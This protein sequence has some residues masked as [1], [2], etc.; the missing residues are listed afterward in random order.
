MDNRQNF[1]DIVNKFIYGGEYIPPK[2][3][4]WFE[5]KHLAEIHSMLGI[6]GVV[7]NRSNIK[8]PLE[9]YEMFDFMVFDGARRG[10]LTES[11]FSDATSALNKA[12]IPHIVVKGYILRDLY[13]EKDMRSMGDI[14]FI[15]K[16][17]DLEKIKDVLVS[18]G[19]K[20]NKIYDGEWSYKKNDMT[21]EFRSGL[22]D[23][24]IGY[25]DYNKYMSNIF[26]KAVVMKGC[27][28]E[29]NN[30]FHFIYMMLHTMKH[31]YGEGCGV[32]MILDIALF[33]K[34][35]KDSLDWKYI[36][37]EFKKLKIE[38]FANNIL[39]VCVR[40]FN[41]DFDA[42]IDDDLYNEIFDYILEGGAF[43]FAR[44]N[45]GVADNRERIEKNKSVFSYLLNKAFPN[46]DTMRG[47]INWYYDKPKI[48]LPV[49]WVY[50]WFNSLYNKKGLVIKSV[51]NVGNTTE[52][53]KQL[54]LLKKMGLY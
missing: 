3:I 32:R 20:L 29:L 53:K 38:L 11:I 48:F 19:F 7:V 2:D 25:M 50:R 52:S 17:E 27:S 24:D 40:M 34:K 9:C 28:F 16:E 6:V 22:V 47:L 39:A 43:G 33:V 49:A 14:D 35:Y 42:K 18:A 54:E 51:V 1:L 13:T 5:I 37:N 4:D 44:N 46:D 31:F 45:L 21:I 12:N 8:M 23:A 41:I 10:I 15:A 30:N 36:K 26:D